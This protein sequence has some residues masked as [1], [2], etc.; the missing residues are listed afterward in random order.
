MSTVTRM[1]FCHRAGS[2]VS[3]QEL[4]KAVVVILITLS[5]LFLQCYHIYFYSFVKD[6]ASQTPQQLCRGCCTL[7]SLCISFSVPSA[8]IAAFIKLFMIHTWVGDASL[9][10]CTKPNVREGL[11]V[12]QR[13]VIP[14]LKLNFTNHLFL[15]SLQFFST[16][17]TVFLSDHI[18]QLWSAIDVFT[19]FPKELHSPNQPNKTVVFFPV[20]LVCVYVYLVRSF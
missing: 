1:P 16:V 5:C 15:M 9:G 18:D 10:A 13:T 17:Q 7:V 3:I 12:G 2:N 6:D 19:V 20:R 14:N 4:C 11:Y 8:S